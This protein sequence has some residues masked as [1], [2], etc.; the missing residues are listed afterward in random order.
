MACLGSIW[1]GLKQFPQ[2]TGFATLELR[3]LL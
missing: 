2:G 1:K 3:M